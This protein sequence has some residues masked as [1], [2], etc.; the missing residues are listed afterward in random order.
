MNIAH[1]LQSHSKDSPND[2]NHRINSS[3][4]G[5]IIVTVVL[6]L[7][8]VLA[9]YL[10]YKLKYTPLTQDYT[11]YESMSVYV[12][13]DSFSGPISLSE[14]DAVKTLH[15]LNTNVKAQRRRDSDAMQFE[16]YFTV[17]IG[18]NDGEADVM[19]CMPENMDLPRNATW[20]IWRDDQRYFTIERFAANLN[21]LDEYWV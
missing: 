3:V 6:V 21:N 14:E 13:G 16:P 4:K 12:T 10:P 11:N 15:Y 19:Y 5:T 20:Y 1:L 9:L 7:I 2:P 17:T 8:A 18:Y